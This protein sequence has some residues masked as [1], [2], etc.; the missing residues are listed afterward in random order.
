[1]IQQLRQ[2]TANGLKKI[3][4]AG[5]FEIIETDK[6]Y[7]LEIK[8]NDRH[9][10]DEYLDLLHFDKRVK[11]HII[12][13]EQSLRIHFFTGTL[14]LNLQVSAANNIYQ[15]DYL[16]ILAFDN[17]IITILKEEN[18]LF[19]DIQEDIENNPFDIP[20]NIYLILYFM[21]S[22][23]LQT[24]LENTASAR[25]SI[26]KLIKRIDDL[27][28]SLS[29]REILEYKQNLSQL[30]SIVDDQ[31][32]I[33]NFRPKLKWSNEKEVNFVNRE[34]KEILRGFEY[35]QQKIEHLEDKL[36]TL[37]MQY[38]LILQ[39]KGNK[40]INTLTV[41]QAIFVPLTLIAGI[42]GMNFS[43]MPELNWYY[44]YFIVIGTMAVLILI[45]LWIFKKRGWFD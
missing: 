5:N 34:L 45:E 28:E 6:E 44:G 17:I 10:V 14:V 31:F 24:G 2:I 3:E 25:I 1:M 35:L 12:E 33:L 38:Q 39:E 26:N 4:F 32:H 40:R 13:P 41:V 18:I 27:S 29:I 21:A 30:A 9:S 36:E 15:V 7:W 23:I 16:T 11:D 20:I 43:H 37:Q 42:Y 22:E 8:S 19:E